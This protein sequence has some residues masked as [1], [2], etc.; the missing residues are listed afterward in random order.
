MKVFPPHPAGY[1]HLVQKYAVRAPALLHASSLADVTAR[2]VERRGG[3]LVELFPRSYDPGEGDI[4]HLVFALKYDGV[5]LAVLGRI[6]RHIDRAELARFIADQPTSKYARRLFF[7]FEF[8]LGERLDVADLPRINYVPLLDPTDYFVSE[9]K[10]SP[11]HRITDNLL[12]DAGFCPIVRRTP[13]LAKATS[14]DLGNRAREITAAADPVLLTRATTYLYTK[15]TRS[16]FAIEREDPGSRLERFVALLATIGER[17]LESE[18]DLAQLQRELVDPRYAESG[19]RRDGDPE[20]YVGETIGFHEKIH[21]IGARSASTPE[22]MRAWSRM[23][24]VVGSGGAVVEAACSSFAFVFIHPFGDGNGRIHRL[25]LHNTLAR[26]G[27]FP[28]GLVVPISAVLLAEPHS[29]DRALE[30]F[31]TR[32]L[33]LIEYKLDPDGSLTI[34]NDNDDLYRYPDLTAVCEATFAWLEQAVEVELVR[35]L[36]FLRRFDEVR[37][38]MRAIVEMPDRKEQNFI[39]ICL[40]NRGKL[41]RSKRNLYPEL[42]DATI[43]ALERVIA[44]VYELDAEPPQSSA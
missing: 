41:S 23:R 3:A 27:Y 33:P 21:H 43:A 28:P 26:R 1:A 10:P 37:A 12:G 22:L 13:A 24:P 30:S 40:A 15:E 7:L 8:L 34:L 44:D 9:G 35:E 38:R 18:A 20:V 39:R 2:R 4:D 5:D 36:D 6:F 31:S 25:L 11:R 17:T 32:V 42:D 29:Y 16:S 19:F 14:K